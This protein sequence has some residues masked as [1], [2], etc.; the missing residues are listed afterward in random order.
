MA[1][2]RASRSEIAGQAA[3]PAAGP[4]SWPLRRAEVR[5]MP[6]RLARMNQRPDFRKDPEHIEQ[7]KPLHPETF[8][9]RTLA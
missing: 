1:L 9:T 6:G 5:R 2:N 8:Y 4:R 7:R 3:A